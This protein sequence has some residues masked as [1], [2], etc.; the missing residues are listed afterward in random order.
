MEMTPLLDVIFL[1]LV[2][3]IYNL[4]VTVEAQSISVGLKPIGSGQTVR[5]ADLAVLLIQ[6]DGSVQLN[7]RTMDRDQLETELRKMTGRPGG[8]TVSIAIESESSQIDRGTVPFELIE[9]L[10]RIGIGRVNFV[11]PKQP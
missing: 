3:F 1:L 7:G 5:E 11:G 10:H 4:V 9:M 8:P 2:F 6:S